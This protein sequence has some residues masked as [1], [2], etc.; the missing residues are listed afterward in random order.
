MR[1]Q[2]ITLICCIMFL[3]GCGQSKEAEGL[4]GDL[5]RMLGNSFEEVIRDLHMKYLVI[6]ERE[7]EV[8]QA[9]RGVNEK[10]EEIYLYCRSVDSVRTLRGGVAKPESFYSKAVSGIA[11]KQGRYW[12]EV[13]TGHFRRP[14]NR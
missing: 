8:Y 7:P 4:E 2:L 5:Q 13:G 3:V 12:I 1:C 6:V 9:I 10:Q 11:Y 14:E